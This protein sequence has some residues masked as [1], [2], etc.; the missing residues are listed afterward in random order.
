MTAYGGAG[1]EVGI[2]HELRL[3]ACGVIENSCMTTCVFA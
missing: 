3:L 1:I 2:L